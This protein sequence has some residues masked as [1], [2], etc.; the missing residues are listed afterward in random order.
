[1]GSKRFIRLSLFATLAWQALPAS[2][3]SFVGSL[4]LWSLSRPIAAYGPGAA[5]PFGYAVSPFYASA[6]TATTSPPTPV[7]PVHALRL[8]SPPSPITPVHALQ[9]SPRLHTRLHHLHAQRTRF[10]QLMSTGTVSYL[11]DACRNYL[12]SSYVQ[13]YL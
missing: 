9:H 1:M 12:V 11:S 10:V 4:A 13:T 6:R 8:P 7:M 5:P 2:Y 3:I